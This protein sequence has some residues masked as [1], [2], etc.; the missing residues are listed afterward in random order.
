MTPIRRLRRVLRRLATRPRPAILM[1][2]RIAEPALDPWGIAVSPARFAEQLDALSRHRVPL[3]MEEIVALLGQGRLPRTAV[4]VTFDDGYRDNATIAKPMLEAAGLPATF[5]L[6]TGAIEQGDPFWWD[7]LAAL[8]LAFEGEVDSRIEI[9]GEIV[10]L[11]LHPLKD[12]ERTGPRWRVAH[13]PR[14]PRESLFIDLWT[15][16]QALDEAHRGRALHRLR[17]HFGPAAMGADELPMSVEEARA[18]P[19]RWIDVGAHSRNHRP[20]TGHGAD[21]LRAELE[22]CRAD[23]RDWF[24]R[25]L[26]GLAYPHGERNA[27]VRAAAAQAG[28][29]WACSTQGEFLGQRAGV[30]VLD[31]PRIAVAGWPG[32]YLLDLLRGR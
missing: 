12:G 25:D 14:T 6:T 4:G 3:P 20:L 2:H 21:M 29:R 13:G 16:L 9:A 17:E 1:Y 28:F 5:F 15:R 11:R 7:E 31:L 26:P 8:V 22:G 23:C 30:D 19:S 18:L 32:A 24:G 27:A 10:T